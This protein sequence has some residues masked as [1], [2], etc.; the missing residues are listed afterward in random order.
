M[1]PRW[2]FEGLVLFILGWGVNTLAPQYSLYVYC[3]I[4]LIITWEIILRL[5]RT[6]FGLKQ[7]KKVRDKT[8]IVM[9]YFIIIILGSTIAV[10]YW[11]AIQKI[12]VPSEPEKTELKEELKVE[13]N[14]SLEKE[15]TESKMTPEKTTSISKE[16]GFVIDSSQVKIEGSIIE[17]EI[18]ARNASTVEIKNSLIKLNIREQEIFL[19]ELRRRLENRWEGLS[20]EEKTKKLSFLAS[21]EKDFRATSDT[22]QR[23]K[24]LDQLH[25]IE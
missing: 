14:K 24:L 2:L 8:G 15:K 5:L 11:A 13:I 17:G 12:F 10:G 16:S 25:E 6:S 18:K 3:F 7:L 20:I 4:L 22:Y 19:G 21:W 23:R 9:S 1:L